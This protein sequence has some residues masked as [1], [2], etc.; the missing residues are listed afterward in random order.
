MPIPL[1]IPAD[2]S[3][4][5]TS[6][7]TYRRLLADELGVYLE[8]TVSAAG[9]TVDARRVVLADEL[10][11]DEADA[12]LGAPYLYVKTGAQ[13]GSQ[14][15]IVAQPDVGYQG[16]RG[17]V[18]LSRPLD[19]PLAV[20]D[21]VEISG[22]LPVTRIGTTKG[23]ND[24]VNEALARIKIHARL[25][26]TG[27]DAYEYPL[28]AYQSILSGDVVELLGI[29]DTRGWTNTVVPPEVR[30]YGYR[31][32]R[33]GVTNTL[34]TD[35]LYSTTDTFYLDVSIYA[36]RLIYDGLGW[37][38]TQQDGRPGL[39]GDDDKAAA[40]EAWAT[41][42]GMVKALQQLDKLVSADASLSD[43]ERTRQVTDILRRRRTWARAAGDI[44]ANRFPKPYEPPSHAFFGGRSWWD[45]PTE[46]PWI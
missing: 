14:R 10:R 9:Q 6:L 44:K 31:I 7:P 34:V 15:R 41:A 16:A 38:Y 26:F 11:D 13:A 43:A 4:G 12:D 40:P 39:Q 18:L 33:N 36:D 22:P 29:S 35:A 21:T 37:A 5:G 42:F 2:I 3:A 17:A 19:A 25:V 46:R 1:V 20:G 45:Q 23:L 27:T 28:A 24:I 32:V 30:P 8:T